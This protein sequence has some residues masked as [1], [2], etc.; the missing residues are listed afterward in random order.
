MAIKMQEIAIPLS[1]FYIGATTLVPTSTEIKAGTIV[2]LDTKGVPVAVG[3][4]NVGA[5]IGE[6]SM[7]FTRDTIELE[8]EQ[9]SGI[10]D[11]GIIFNNE[12]LTMTIPVAQLAYANLQQALQADAYDAAFEAPA[13]VSPGKILT[14]GGKTEPATF[15]VLL[16]A[17]HRAGKG[18]F[19]QFCIYKCISAEG[20]TLSFSKADAMTYEIQCRGLLDASRDKGD[21]LGYYYI[22]NIPAA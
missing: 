19:H 2:E 6:G 13:T 5:T 22:A 17:E 7:E 21:Q 18:I 4:K 8:V 20:T 14:I 12:G 15:S 3:W 16:V 11:G 1:E 10:P 9:V